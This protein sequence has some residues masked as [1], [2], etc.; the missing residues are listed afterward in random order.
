MPKPPGST[1]RWSWTPVSTA[2]EWQ[3]HHWWACCEEA[4]SVAKPGGNM[5]A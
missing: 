1:L 3:W 5:S 4:L 2:Q